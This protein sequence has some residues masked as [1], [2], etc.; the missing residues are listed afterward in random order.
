MWQAVLLDIE[1]LIM[2]ASNKSNDQHNYS[3]WKCC[4]NEWDTINNYHNQEVGY[5]QYLGAWSNTF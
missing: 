4:S 1:G 3:K 2:V 5:W